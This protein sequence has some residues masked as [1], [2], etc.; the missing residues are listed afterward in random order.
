MDIQVCGLLRRLF[1]HLLRLTPANHR[2]GEGDQPPAGIREDIDVT[3]FIPCLNEE[4]RIA[5]T[6]ETLRDALVGLTL[7]FEAIVVDD[8]STDHTSKMAEEF[9]LAHPEM[10][11]RIIRN[12]KNLGLAHSFVDAAFQGRGRYYRLI[13]G[14]NIEPKESIAAVLGRLG[15][16]DVIIPYYPEVPGKSPFRMALSKAFTG[17]INIVSGHQLHYY[18]GN[19]LY[20]RFD[21]MRWAPHNFGFGYQADLLTQ[22]LD[23][24][25]SYIETPIEGLHRPKTGGSSLRMRNLM[26]VGHSILEISLRRLRKMFFGR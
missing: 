6:L 14:D 1:L 16:A 4:T 21:V 13:C 11:I 8:G 12:P 25:V 2:T 15:D 19:P 18:N 26:S 5:S 24:N 22:L 10:P 23:Q 7:T 3:F 9:R 17:A 20:R